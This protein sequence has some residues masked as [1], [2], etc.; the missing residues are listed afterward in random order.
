VFHP[1]IRK[2]EGQKLVL[3]DHGFFS[4]QGNPPDLIICP[5]GSWN[6][7]MNVETVLSMLTAVCHFKHVTH[8]VWAYFQ[9][10]LALTIAAFKLMIRRSGLKPDDQ[11]FFHLSIVEFNL[12]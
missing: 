12:F 4:K 11:G 8:R 2:F 1:L 5:R 9:A 6:V 3:A 10:R 7:R